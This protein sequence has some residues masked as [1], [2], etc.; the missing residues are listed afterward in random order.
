MLH[1]KLKGR[2]WSV[3][4]RPSRL[5]RWEGAGFPLAS[6]TVRQSRNALRWTCH[7]DMRCTLPFPGAPDTL[8]AAP[9]RRA[10][11]TAGV[12]DDGLAAGVPLLGAQRRGGVDPRR[13][14]AAEGAGGAAAPPHGALRRAA[15]GLRAFLGRCAGL[16]SGF[17][18]G[19]EEGPPTAWRRLTG[20]AFMSFASSE[21]RRGASL[22]AA[23][24]CEKKEEEWG[25]LRSSR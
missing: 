14:P 12:C 24:V 5:G 9:D 19:T 1:F 2:P 3:T 21:V 13:H 15:R 6:K 22:F 10:G 25:G 16:P 7:P 4:L 20:R 23:E 8:L 17:C 11:M 18:C